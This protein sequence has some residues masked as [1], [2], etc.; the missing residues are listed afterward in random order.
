MQRKTSVPCSASCRHHVPLR[1]VPLQS[2]MGKSDPLHQQCTHYWWLPMQW[3]HISMEE[4][5]THWPL[6]EF[7]W[8]FTWRNLEF[9]GPWEIWM[10]FY[11]EE[12]W[13]YWPLGNLNEILHGGILNSLALG[14]F[15]WNFTWRN[16]ELIGSWEIWMKFY[17]EESWTH[18]PLGNLNEILHGG[19]LNSLAPRKFEWNFTWRNLE[20]IGPWEIWMK[21]Y[22]EESWTHWP[23]GNLNEIL[24][25]GILNSLAPRK[26]ELN[27][28]WRNLELIGP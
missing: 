23:L 28:T 4:S 25:G 24:H 7:E 15:E 27:F 6:G 18:W 17:M 11:M 12:S 16:L 26:S 19:I 5:W 21:F 3:Y 9:I 20:L 10:K 13:T 8:N 1:G 14:N 2:S 22:M